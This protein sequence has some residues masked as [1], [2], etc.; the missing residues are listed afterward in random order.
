[1]FARSETTGTLIPVL[2]LLPLRDAR[3]T[4]ALASILCTHTTYVQQLLSANLAAVIRRNK[5][6]LRLKPS[7]LH[8]KAER[9]L[10]AVS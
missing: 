7:P 9:A 1:L 6:P 3:A 4:N 5:G 8:R 2:T 10:H